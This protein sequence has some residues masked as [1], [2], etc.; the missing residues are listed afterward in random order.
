MPDEK[1]GKFGNGIS[2]SFLP[3][4]EMQGRKSPMT[5]FRD[6]VGKYISMLPVFFSGIDRNL[7]PR[8]G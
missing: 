3:I 6:G 7:S 4:S 2:F 1:Q 8:Y 5:G